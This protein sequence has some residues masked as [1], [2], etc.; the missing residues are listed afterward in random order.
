M[1]RNETYI[2]PN[3]VEIPKLGLGTW[4]IPDA[5]AADAVKA[6]VTVGYRHFDTAQAYENERGVGEGVRTCGLPGNSFSSPARWRRST[7]TMTAP[8]APLT[9]PSLKWGW[10]IW[11]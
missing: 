5:Q 1:I 7:R 11:T 3:G 8:P 10:T 6:A 4:F 2:L 9:R